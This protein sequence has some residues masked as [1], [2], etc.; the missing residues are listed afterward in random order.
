VEV[1]EA[2]VAAAA[3]KRRFVRVVGADTRSA[4]EVSANG[5]QPVQELEVEVQVLDEALPPDYVPSLIKV[6][7]EGAELE[8]L[9]GGLATL[10]RHKPIVAFELDARGDASGVFEVL[11]Q[12]VGLRI[13][14]MDGD[15][16]LTAD[17]LRTKV[18][19]KSHWNFI[20]HR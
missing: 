14:D 17:A 10:T 12:R 7:V 20:A 13:F 6:D 9:Q 4:F 18:A 16:P 1:R 8:V 2:A 11:A 3:G 15:G 19:R 5:S